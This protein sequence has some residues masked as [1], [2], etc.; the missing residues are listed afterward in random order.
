MFYAVLLSLILLCLMVG[1]QQQNTLLIITST[2]Y[3]TILTVMQQW[4]IKDTVYIYSFIIFLIILTSWILFQKYPLEEGFGTPSRPCTMYFTTDKDGCDKGYYALSDTDFQKVLVQQKNNLLIKVAENR[5]KLKENKNANGICKQEFPGWLEDPDQ[6]EKIPYNDISNNGALKDWAFCYRNV[7]PTNTPNALYNPI[8]VQNNYVKLINDFGDHNIAS[9]DKAP[10]TQ[11]PNN[12]TG[13]TVY[14]KATPEYARIYFKEWKVDSDASCKNP[15][16]NTIPSLN[17][18]T[19]ITT[20]YGIE[21]GLT[22]DQTKITTISTIRPSPGNNNQ[23]VYVGDYNNPDLNILEKLFFDYVIEPNQGLKLRAK[24]SIETYLYRFYI[25]FCGR[26]MVPPTLPFNLKTNEI[27]KWNLSSITGYDNILLTNRE[28]PFGITLPTNFIDSSWLLTDPLKKSVKILPYN[29]KTVYTKEQ[30]QLILQTQTN[31]LETYLDTIVDSPYDSNELLKRGLVTMKYSLPPKYDSYRINTLSD[32]KFEENINLPVYLQNM[33][34][35]LATN[36]GLSIPITPSATEST[37]ID[38]SGFLNIDIPGKYEFKLVFGPVITSHYPVES[39]IVVEV[40]NSVVASYFACKNYDECYPIYNVNCK[41]EIECKVPLITDLSNKKK[42][43]VDIPTSKISRQ[44][45]HNPVQI[46]IVNKQNI[47]RIRV[48]T[49]KGALSSPN[50]CYVLYRKIE[51]IIIVNNQPID[52][53]RIIGRQGSDSIWKGYVNDIIQYRPYDMRPSLIKNMYIT[54]QILLNRNALYQ[55]EDRRIKVL[56]SFLQRIRAD[57]SK[58]INISNQLISQNNRIYAF[59]TNPTL[60]PSTE[61]NDLEKIQQ[62][63][64][65]FRTNV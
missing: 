42:P 6:P 18:L 2:L 5:R 39:T 61:V 32:Y 15:A 30:I 1:I 37:Y 58:I 64:D 44:K 24:S 35:T 41:K 63:N 60:I 16:V 21:I 34:V 26:L 27:V 31:Q 33:S 55:I 59:F 4:N 7:L 10:Y 28:Y 29:T 43:L 23:L 46:D 8:D 17:T 48:Y 36:D 56:N 52:N 65:N 19:P 12:I 13:Q 25:D 20:R 53:F 22:E 62:F 38:Y 54:K 40:N 14:S 9:I 50:I 49:P 3:L 47:L 45:I 11:A 51:D 57:P